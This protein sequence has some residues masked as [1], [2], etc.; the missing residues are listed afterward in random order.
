M[1]LNKAIIQVTATD[2][3]SLALERQGKD[4]R[5]L[6]LFDETEDSLPVITVASSVVVERDSGEVMI[7]KIHY[8]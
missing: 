6:F 5:I 4:Q 1:K 2:K 7:V 3:I 8:Q